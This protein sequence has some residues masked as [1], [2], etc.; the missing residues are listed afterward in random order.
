MNDIE[1]ITFGF[2]IIPNEFSNEKY[3]SLTDTN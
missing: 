3:L 1:T 2:N